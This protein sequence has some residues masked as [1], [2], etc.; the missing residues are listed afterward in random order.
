MTLSWLNELAIPIE[1]V[2]YYPT[3]WELL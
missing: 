2:G 3:S 1:L